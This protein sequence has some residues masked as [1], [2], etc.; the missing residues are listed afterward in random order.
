MADAPDESVAGIDTDLVLRVM[1]TAMAIVH[2]AQDD[3]HAALRQ[4]EGELK[5]LQH[6]AAGS[7]WEPMAAML[8]DNVAAVAA[9][10]RGDHDGMRQA[11]QRLQE[12]ATQLPP[13]LQEVRQ[14]VDDTVAMAERP[15]LPGALRP[16]YLLAAGGASLGWGNETDLDRIGAAIDSFRQAVA[17]AEPGDS[18]RTFSL[19]SLGLAL[20]R[21]AEVSGRNDGLGEAMRVLTQARDL[22]VGPKDPLWSM[23]SEGVAAAGRLLGQDA[24]ARQASLEGL[25]RYAWRVLLQSDAEAATMAAADAADW[26][27]DAA[28][29]CLVDNAPEDAVRALDAGRGLALFAAVEFRDVMARLEAA[30]QPDLARRWRAAT[31][32]RGP[33]AAPA[34]LRAELLSA[35]ATSAGP[36]T[37]DGDAWL[38]PPGLGEIRSALATL[39]ADALVYLV[40]GNAH[41]AGQTLQPGWAVIVPVDGVCCYLTLPHLVLD[42]DVDVER[43]LAAV[44]RRDALLAAPRIGPVAAGTRDADS[45]AETRFEASLDTLC[46]WAWRAAIGPLL[47]RYLVT[48]P[49]PASGRPHRVVLIPIGNLARVPWQAARRADGRYAVE[50]AAFSQAVSARMLCDSAAREPV[51]LAPV[52]LVVGDPDTAGAAYELAAARAEAYAIRQSF[53]PG[54]RYVGRRP[55]GTPSRSGPG[56]D[57]DVRDWLAST[58]PGAGTML[59][60]ACHGVVRA[61]PGD[62]TSYLLLAGGDR[63][64]AEEL[65]SAM[66]RTPGRDIGLV[67]LAACRTGVSSRG[68]DEAYS[69]GTAFLAGGARSVLSTQW[70]V[71]DRATSV[72]MFVFHHYLMAERRPVW[73]ALRRAQLWMLDPQRQP[74]ERMPAG[75]RRQL[76]GADPAQVAAW[77]GFVHWGR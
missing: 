47:D 6:L 44:S 53:Y 24:G 19:L 56:T 75:L 58:R 12:S 9:S 15:D 11:L 17:Q 68:Y 18:L 5:A 21:R 32:S 57:G 16:R 52:G 66:G 3:D 1:S 38:D 8:I 50:L 27:R 63:L 33:E 35:L 51:P 70:S 61:D 30:G 7:S 41:D 29:A 43:C 76:A 4:A 55:D 39:D 26:A 37:G 10:Q 20:L 77:A 54:A 48:R 59:H 45:T 40:P 31:A 22:S 42:D 67:V 2:A 23:A 74:P 46:D 62:T 14:A 71:P 72:L 36:G 25:R 28:L 64:A 34:P 65:T 13:D 60:L 49:A 69:L 73:D